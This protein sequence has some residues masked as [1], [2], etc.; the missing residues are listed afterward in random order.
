MFNKFLSIF[1]I[2]ILSIDNADPKHGLVVQYPIHSN[3][4]ESTGNYPDAV[5]NGTNFSTD[6]YSNTDSALLFDGF[7]QVVEI[8]VST[9]IG[10]V[11]Y[12]LSFWV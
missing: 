5:N 1:I 8:P 11:D 7:P 6:K 4:E 12:T 2:A 9:V 10:L 3:F